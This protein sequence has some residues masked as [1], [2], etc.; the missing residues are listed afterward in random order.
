MKKTVLVFVVSALV[1]TGLALW[2]LKGQLSGN[3]G[4][5]LMTAGTL[6]VA[7]FGLFLG[8]R[9]LRSHRQKEPVEDELSKKVMTR[10]S[11]LSYYISLYLWLLVMYFS[12]RVSMPVNSLIGAG[13][14]GMAL[15]FML[16]WIGVRFFGTQ[17]D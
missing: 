2:A 10:A 8:I 14:L 6:L 3:T 13:I 9:R 1:L 17:N 15:I 11:S 16:S 4:E 12:D 7:G 5:I